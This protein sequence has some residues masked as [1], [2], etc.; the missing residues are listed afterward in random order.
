MGELNFENILSGDEVENLF[1]DDIENEEIVVDKNRTLDQPPKEDDKNI[2]TTEVNPEMLFEDKPES[3]GSEDKVKE[4]E[5]DTT[6]KE[7]GSSPK[8]NFYSS[9]AKALQEEGI[10]PDLENTKLDQIS[11]PEDFAKVVEDVVNSKLDEKQKRINEALEV[12]VEITDI[13]R[14]ENTIEYLNSIDNNVLVDEGEQGET[15]RKQLIYQDFINRGYSEER[16]QR[17]IKK[18]ITGGTDIEDA[19]EALKSNK[20][21][22]TKQYRDLID[23]GK[24]EEEK[25]INQRKEESQKLKKSLLEDNTAFGEIQLDKVTRQQI[26][27]NITKPIYRDPN[28]GEYLT[29]IQ[30]YERENK[31]EFIKNLSLLFTLTDGFKSLDKLVKGK[32]KTEVKKGLRELEATINNTSRTMDGNLKFVSGVSDDPEA[33]IGK[34]W[35]LDV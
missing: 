34:G 35:D 29:S 19:K 10:F 31:T 11:T 1:A 24:K 27:D 20:E 17:E 16:A 30:K 26:Y 18:S 9:I 2:E 13:K 25:V 21:F 5:K 28:T 23:I 4:A 3:V 33:S 22:F 7:A 12:G 32:V 8:I 15:L 6:S 14:Y